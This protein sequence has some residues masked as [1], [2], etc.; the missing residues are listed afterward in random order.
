MFQSSRTRLILAISVLSVL[1]AAAILSVFYWTSSTILESET[2]G[3][4]TAELAGLEDDYSRLGL[5][6]LARA[7]ERRMGD[8]SER[9]AVYLLTDA[10]GQTI[11]GNLGAWPPTVQAGKGWVELELFRTDS[12]KRVMILAASLI[13]SDGERLLVGRDSAARQR[14]ERALLQ[15]GILALGMAIVL[16]L[17]LGWLLTRLVY[18]RVADISHTAEDIM[19]GEFGR[20]IPT[21][22]RGDEFDRLSA[23]LNTMFDRIE[24]LIGNL[25]T[26]TDSL[27]HDLRSPLTRLR[28]Q[29]DILLRPDSSEDEKFEA[30]QRAQGEIDH[31]LRVFTAMT[32]ISRAEAGLARSEFAPVDLEELAEDAVDLYEPVAAEQDIALTFVG[33]SA[34]IQGSAPML[35]QAISNLIENALTYTPKGGAIIV[36]LSSSKNQVCLTVADNGP[37]IAA[38]DLER[39]KQRFVTLDDSRSSRSTGLGLAL[40]NAVAK[41]HGGDLALSD[42]APGLRAALWLASRND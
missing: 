13:L 42:N 15:A 35:A 22:D 17:V 8:A 9:D 11:T 32:E 19:S 26:T 1:V 14:F 29:V 39:V 4:V 21:Y 36:T 24:A 3:V 41:M 25:R 18:S 10:F 20:R 27:A 28:G 23:T 7:I 33:S 38:A 2:R 30:A 16:S 40:V 34:V 5:I 6:G 12:D 37:G 31:V